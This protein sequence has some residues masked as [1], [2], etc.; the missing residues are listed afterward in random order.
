MPTA[1]LVRVCTPGGR[2]LATGFCWRRPPTPQA[3]EVLLGQA[4]PGLQF[5]TIEDGPP[6]TS[7]PG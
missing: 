5:D 1:E 2:V 7:G 6:A 4:C 3:R